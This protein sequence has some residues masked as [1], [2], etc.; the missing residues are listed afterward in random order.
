MNIVDK[1]K[2]LFLGVAAEPAERAVPQPVQTRSS[3]AGD[4]AHKFSE[5]EVLA[6]KLR[7]EDATRLLNESLKIA[8]QSKS[9]ETRNSR[10]QTVRDTLYELEDLASKY[11]I[12]HL[13]N[14]QEV[15]AS[16]SAVELETL[17]L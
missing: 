13:T 6:V 15:E 2:G 7:A 11:P 16:I 10:L 4:S 5:S 9:L 8:N 1:L 17:S 3:E 14:L 12:L